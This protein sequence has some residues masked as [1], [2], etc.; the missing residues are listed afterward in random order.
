MSVPA[1][2]VKFLVPCTRCLKFFNAFEAE[3]CDCIGTD[4]TLR[5]PHCWHCFCRAA[6][7]YKTEF[8]RMAPQ[9]L[10]DMHKERLGTTSPRDRFATVSHEAP[11]EISRPMVLVVDDS[12]LIRATTLRIVRSLGYGAVEAA[13]ADQALALALL[14][15][16]EVIL[17]DALMPRMD[18]RDLCRTIK[19]DKIMRSAKV[20]IMTGLYK[21]PRYKYEAFHSFGA[22]DYVLKPIEP[23]ELRK[24]LGTLVGPPQ[25]KT[26]PLNFDIVA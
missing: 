4:V 20:V 9:A 15:Q 17:T 13:D 1:L 16:P 25:A 12:K 8:W 14:Y 3:W 23:E 11:A 6:N 24:L 5:C 19:S 22:D 18:G 26:P 10:H 21:A 2:E 7:E